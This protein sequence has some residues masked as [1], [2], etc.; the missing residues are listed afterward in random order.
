MAPGAADPPPGVDER[1]REI[2]RG[3]H[4][5][6]LYRGVRFVVLFALAL[7]GCSS[8]D[9]REV[10]RP[11]PLA[12]AT[13]SPGL[14][15]PATAAP[16]AYDVQL[17]IDPDRETFTGRVAIRVQLAA[18]ARE[19]W[20]HADE[21]DITSAGHRGRP[22][23]VGPPTEHGMRA[24]RFDRELPAGEVTVELSYTGAIGSAHEGL[25]RER[26]GGTWFVYSQAEAT[27]ARRIVPCFDEPRFKVPWRVTLVVP[28]GQ[29]ALANAPLASER[30]LRDG[31]REVTFA[32]MPAL[33]PHLFAIA[34]GPFALVELPPLGTRRVPARAAVAPHQ[35]KRLDAARTWTPKLV[36]MLE[37]YVAR[38]LPLAKLD[39][40]AVPDFFGAMENPGLV[41]ID[42]SGLVGNAADPHFLRRHVRF[43][44][45]E[46]AHQ[47]FGNALTPAWWDDLWLAEAFATWFDD[48]LSNALGTRDDPALRTQQARAEALAA[49]RAATAVPLRRP[50]ASTEDIEAAFDAISY[51]KGAAVL[52]MFEHFLGESKFRDAVR[53][54]IARDGS[55]TTEDFISALAGVDAAAAAAFRGYI[56][57][58]GAPIVDFAIDCTAPR[59]VATPRDGATVPVCIRHLNGTA[60]A[61]AT[62]ATSIALASCPAWIAPNADG[63][64]YYHAHGYAPPL[65]QLA[66]AER[67]ALGH[68]RAAA[69]AR[70]ELARTAALAEV[71][72]LLAAREPYAELAALAI[73]D[74][75]DA[76][77][78]EADYPRWSA[79]VATKLARRLTRAA[80]WQPRSP[81][82]LAARDAVVELV[83]ATRFPADVTQLARTIVERALRQGARSVH[84]DHLA[85]AL[86]LAAPAGGKPLFDRIVTAALQHP[87]ARDVWLAGLAAF[88]PALAPDAVAL[89]LDARFEPEA[90]WDVVAGMLA[91]TATRDA[92]WRAVHARLA[93][94]TAAVGADVILA[95]SVH[96]CSAEARGQIAAAFTAPLARRTLAAIDA[97]VRASG[98]PTAP[99]AP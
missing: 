89:V 85:L 17:A 27:F 28:A 38:P 59:V 52:A 3:A 82:E 75:L 84:P 99:P 68:D 9:A 90:A 12:P 20:L 5:T 83:P 7:A 41:T 92:A 35:A 62:G 1:R 4:R 26:S 22:I 2:A 43:L 63:R 25:F 29:V 95:A 42:A 97:C 72:A 44:A 6:A 60:C 88:D 79:L 73:L 36:A 23:V 61:L 81:R 94:L 78:A 56:V 8:R 30:T 49:D 51:E 66:P 64:G 46:L 50:I 77:V 54:Y 70:G 71:D 10:T 40:V 69:V 18:A 21:L 34:V 19:I 16:L 74:A 48:K 65:A 86:V 57:R 87:A 47:W 45:H 37:D 32:E 39:L 11:P 13:P 98:V 96:L 55:A 14:R 93:Q 80:I 15:L 24:L 67:L 76:H 58:T 31:R 91:R 53:A 33:P